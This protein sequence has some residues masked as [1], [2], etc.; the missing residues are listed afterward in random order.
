M[1]SA[2]EVP[3]ENSLM[4]I[5]MQVHSQESIEAALA[6]VGKGFRGKHGKQES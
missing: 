6:S 3:L 4:S 5:T 1:T 2:L